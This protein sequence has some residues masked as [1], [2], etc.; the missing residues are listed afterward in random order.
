MVHMETA[1]PTPDGP[2]ERTADLREHYDAEFDALVFADDPDD[3]DMF[4]MGDDE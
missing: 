4:H 1:M 3:Y 2:E